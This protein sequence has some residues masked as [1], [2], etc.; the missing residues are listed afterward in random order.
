MM[1]AV[2]KLEILNPKK[3]TKYKNQIPVNQLNVNY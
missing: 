1:H 2:D 3:D